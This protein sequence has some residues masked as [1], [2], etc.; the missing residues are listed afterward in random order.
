[1][2]AQNGTIN[3]NSTKQVEY[4]KNGVFNLTS[5][6]DSKSGKVTSTNEQSGTLEN[7]VSAIKN[8]SSDT[9]CTANF[10]DSVTTLYEDGTLIINEKMD[11]RSANISTHG[12]VAKEY[13]AMSNSNSYVFTVQCIADKRCTS[14]VLWF[15]ER[16]NILNVEIGGNIKL[17]STSNWFLELSNMK[18]C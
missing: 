10:I 1:M 5:N 6:I 13:D 3:E 9:T 17:I 12:L 15:Q 14:D 11:N 4:N 16:T 18:I 7:G 2:V 8:V